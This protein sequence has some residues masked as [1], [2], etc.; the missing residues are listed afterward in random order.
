MSYKSCIRLPKASLVLILS[1][2]LAGFTL[3]TTSC[4]EGTAPAE[5]KTSSS[6]P[7][8]EQVPEL[9]IPATITFDGLWFRETMEGN[10]TK[11]LDVG[12]KVTIT[13]EELPDPEKPKIIYVPVRL[14]DGTEG[15]VS[16][17]F[18][19]PESYPGVLT[20]N[21]KLYSEA[22]LSKLT[23][24]PDI[25]AMTIVAIGNEGD[26][27][28]FVKVSFATPDG[29][30]KWDYWVKMDLVS[31]QEKDIM[32]A[33]LYNLAMQTEDESIKTEFLTSASEMQSP[34][35]GIYIDLELEGLMEE[36]PVDLTVATVIVL[37]DDTK[38]FSSADYDSSVAGVYAKNQ[39]LGVT[40]R[41]SAKDTVGG[42]EDWWYSL[43]DGSWIFGADLKVNK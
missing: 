34:A 19:V 38:A 42:K 2:A 36:T 4:N 27:N 13:G 7:V 16:K 30:A 37:N 22:K 20:Q 1:L 5:N 6:E 11:Q 32:A 21:A 35:F 41:S 31:Y 10:G 26:V 33:H 14:E 40:G 39:I 23:S 25:E 28:G 18:A 17:W 12:D 8:V 43:E 29:Y 9:A 3:L 15:Y 24:E